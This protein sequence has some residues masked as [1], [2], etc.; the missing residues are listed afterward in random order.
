MIHLLARISHQLENSHLHPNGGGATMTRPTPRKPFH[1]TSSARWVNSL[2][3]V[4]LILSLGSALL[5]LLV[6]QWLQ[7]YLMWSS[8]ARPSVDNIVARQIRQ[9]ATR[10]WKVRAFLVAVPV[11]LEVAILLF[12]SGLAILLWTLDGQVAIVVSTTSVSFSLAILM[13][14]LL[15]LW[16]KGCPYQS[17][18]AHAVIVSWAIV[19]HV[20]V[21]ANITLTAFCQALVQCWR[22]RAGT[23]R[24]T[25]LRQAIRNALLQCGKRWSLLGW[26]ALALGRLRDEH[27]SPAEDKALDA[28]SALR[29]H[30]MTEMTVWCRE[31]DIDGVELPAPIEELLGME[32]NIKNIATVVGRIYLKLGALTGIAF[33][34]GQDIQLMDHV[35]QCMTQVFSPEVRTRL[36]VGRTLSPAELY[37]CRVLVHGIKHI[38]LWCILS[39]FLTSPGLGL[40][41]DPQWLLNMLSA[42]ALNSNGRP[43]ETIV[44]LLRRS[45]RYE[46]EVS[47]STNIDNRIFVSQRR[48]F[49]RNAIPPWCRR[50]GA[51]KRKLLGHLFACHLNLSVQL[52]I[53]LF[54]QAQAEGHLQECEIHLWILLNRMVELV[55]ILAHLLRP[56]KLEWEPSHSYEFRGWSTFRRGVA[57]ELTLAYNTL[58]TSHWKHGAESWCGGL[59]ICLMELLSLCSPWT[60]LKIDRSSGEL[61]PGK[62]LYVICLRTLFSQLSS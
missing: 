25:L 46:E 53:S 37:G 42:R 40:N 5:G 11:M 54:G 22:N 55:R 60:Q 32:Q 20:V 57:R 29:S 18:T 52:M 51:Q 24:R 50:L 30:L 21:S 47:H 31:P 6:K 13:I 59:R 15:P 35:G 58:S 17:P 43:G 28:C 16:F 34:S 49:A 56:Q 8:T 10:V 36:R 12:L 62:Y 41:G 19:S 23:S 1:P 44:T 45:V 2:W 27:Y 4:S 61:I 38:S 39:L 7:H 14:T 9:R 26:Q 48:T 3:L 33:L